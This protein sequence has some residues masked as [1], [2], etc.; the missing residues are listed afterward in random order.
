MA[1]LSGRR[2][3]GAR[4]Q[5]SNSAGGAAELSRQASENCRPRIKGRIPP[6][7]RHTE[8]PFEQGVPGSLCVQIPGAW[9]WIEYSD[10]RAPMNNVRLSGPPN[11]RPEARSGVSSV[12]ICLPFLS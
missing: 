9:V 6:L 5:R 12:P 10:D 2:S 8:T 3:S 4:E 1:P 7:R 11:A